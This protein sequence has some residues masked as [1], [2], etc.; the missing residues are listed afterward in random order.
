MILD[1]PLGETQTRPASTH[2]ACF[3]FQTYDKKRDAATLTPA[4]S[5]PSLSFH[6]LLDAIIQKIYF[7][8]FFF[9]HRPLFTA[10]TLG[11][12]RLLRILEYVDN[13]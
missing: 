6:S 8:G 7:T 5:P 4:L 10:D 2:E 9:F 3:I 1:T 12:G 13:A 11:K